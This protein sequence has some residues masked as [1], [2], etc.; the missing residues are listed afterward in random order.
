MRR[1]LSETMRTGL[2][3]GLS[4]TILVLVALVSLVASGRDSAA[5]ASSAR[6]RA[7]VLGQKGFGVP[8]STGWGTYK[9][10]EFFNGGD[11]SGEVVAISW[12]HWGSHVA[13]GTGRGFIFM[14]KGGYYPGSVRVDVRAEDLGHC[15]SNGPPAYEHL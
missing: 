2:L 15:T 4:G 7:P 13:T 9:P 14:P 10:S 12:K 6:I 1:P 3:V 5:S 11:P 8:S